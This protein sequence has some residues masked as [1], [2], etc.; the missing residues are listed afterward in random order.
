MGKEIIIIGGGITGLTIGYELSKEGFKVVIIEKEKEVGGLGRSFRYGDFIF[1]IG[2]HRFYTTKDNIL[3]FINNILQDEKKI[4]AR[5][6]GVYLFSK[7]YPWPLHPLSVLKLPLKITVESAL[8]LLFRKSN[9]R[10]YPSSNFENYI[11]KQYGPTLYNAFFK[12]YTEKF[13]GLSAEQTHA[14]WAESGIAHAII[15]ERIA[16][17]NLSGILKASILPRAIRTEFIY[18]KGGMGVFCKK[19]AEGIEAKGGVILTD[20]KVSRLRY[21]NGN[22]NMVICDKVSYISEK[23]I[24]T[25][26]VTELYRFLNLSP[27]INLGYLS[28]LLF[29]IEVKG[30]VDNNYQWCYFGEKDIVFSRISIPYLFDPNLSPKGKIGLCIEI[31]CRENDENWN[32]PENLTNRIKADLRKVGFIEIDKDIVSIHIE[33]IPNA[34]PIYKL[35]YRKQFVEAKIKLQGFSN[36][37]LAGRSGLFWYNN[38]DDC[39]ENG[40]DIAKNIIH[41]QIYEKRLASI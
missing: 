40:L 39:I 22:I 30:L 11:I 29:F 19:L 1:D 7:Y 41:S 4:I 3:Q 36:L 10:N 20:T 6:S 28:L 12:D 33:R 25:A 15:D 16:C 17:R 24:W 13:L 14:D 34:Y 8:D 18:P 21:S 5:H 38:M 31:S 23:V 9:K 35:D 2:P 26:P 37:I 27:D 32:K